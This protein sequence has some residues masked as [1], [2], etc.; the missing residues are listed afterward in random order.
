MLVQLYMG[1]TMVT[2]MLNDPR[3]FNT[4]SAGLG[5][6]MCCAVQYLCALP[7]IRSTVLQGVGPHF[8]V[9]GNPYAERYRPLMLRMADVTL[10][11]DKLFNGFVKLRV[12]PHAIVGAVHGTLI[13]GG[14]AA[15]LH[16]DYI[17][18]DCRS[19]FEHGNLV[20][21]VCVLGM[22][23]QTFTLALGTHAQHIYLQN[24]QLD[25][26]TA[27]AAGLVHRL[28]MGITA[29]QMNAREIAVRLLHTKDLVQCMT[30]LRKAIDL[31]VVAGEAHHDGF[32]AACSQPF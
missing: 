28:C 32:S 10:S 26:A 2:L 13:G 19:M 1:A 11:L 30:C 24:S 18:A 7:G 25:A 16:A 27:H 14:I 6:D 31:A 4:F 3:H 15:C 20:R 12:L 21:G 29:T 22:L 9:G 8:S 17:T 23:S 5:Q